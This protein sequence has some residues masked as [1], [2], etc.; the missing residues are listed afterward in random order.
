MTFPFTQQL[1]DSTICPSTNKSTNI[2]YQYSVNSSA[3][4][5][6]WYT[7]FKSTIKNNALFNKQACSISATPGKNPALG[8]I[9]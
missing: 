7:N 6:Y 5:N 1:S 3:A 4:T 2:K 8:Q 9:E